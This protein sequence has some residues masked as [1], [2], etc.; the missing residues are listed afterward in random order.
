M[1]RDE[2][3]LPRSETGQGCPLPSLLFNITLE[4][5]TN[6]IKQ[7]SKIKGIQIGNKEIKLSLFANDMIVYVGNLNRS[8]KKPLELIAR[9]QNKRLIYKSQLL[10]YIPVM[11]KW[12]LKLK[13]HCHLH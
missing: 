6:E 7:E 1:V 2:G 8:T 4:G 5:L 9:L 3:F 13:T 12:N 10:S 11:N